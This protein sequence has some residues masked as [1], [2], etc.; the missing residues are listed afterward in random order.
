MSVLVGQDPPWKTSQI[1]FQHCSLL[2]P[3]DLELMT[4][5]VCVKIERYIEMVNSV[6]DKSA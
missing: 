3:D 2:Q 6:L 1:E 4:E 5:T